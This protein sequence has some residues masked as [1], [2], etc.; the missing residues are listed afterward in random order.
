[1]IDRFLARVGTLGAIAIL[2]VAVLATGV[3]GGILEHVRLSAQHA[4]PQQ[5]GE[6][7]GSQQ[8]E[9][10]QES[11]SGDQ[12]ANQSDNTDQGTQSQEGEKGDHETATK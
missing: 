6:Q 10:K 9:S 5:Q 7:A 12:G 4:Q 2:T 8:G 1:M 11:Q 3:A